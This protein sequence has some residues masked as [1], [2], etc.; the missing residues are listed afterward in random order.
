MKTKILSFFDGDN[1]LQDIIV[2]KLTGKDAVPDLMKAFNNAVEAAKADNVE[3][4]SWN[5]PKKYFKNE[6]ISL[7]RIECETVR[8]EYL[9]NTSGSIRIALC[10]NCS[11]N[12]GGCCYKYGGLTN[13]DEERDCV[14]GTDGYFITYNGKQ[15]T[16]LPIFTELSPEEA[17]AV[18][19]GSGDDYYSDLKEQI[20]THISDVLEGEAPDPKKYGFKEDTW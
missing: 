18:I 6:G 17:V 16:W 15:I 10:K 2:V 19:V 9:E 7:K 1:P 14:H 4:Y 8:A 3:G 20:E 11:A 5:I 13:G 12:D